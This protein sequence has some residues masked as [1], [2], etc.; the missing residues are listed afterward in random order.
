MVDRSVS[1]PRRVVDAD[2]LVVG[3]GAGAARTAVAAAEAGASTTVVLKKTLGRSGA[4]NYPRK[5]AYGS[6]WQAADGCS[7]RDD[8]PDLHYQDVMRAALGMADARMARTLAHESPER[9]LEIES[10]GFRLIPD[11]EG[12]RRH[13]AGYSCFATQPRAHGMVADESGGHTGNMIAVLAARFGQLGGQVDPDTTVVDLL[14]RDGACVGAL[15]IDPDGDLIAYRTGA[16]VLATGGASQMFPLS[17]TPGEITGDG[18]GMAFRAGGELVNLEFM[19]YMW[20][21][22]HGTPP[23]VGGPFWSLNPAVRGRDGADLLAAAL[24]PGVAAERVFHDRTLHYPFSSRDDGRWLDIAVQRAIRAGRGTARGGVTV[25]FSGV[26]LARARAPRPQHH[27]P[28]ATMG[29]GDPRIEVT[30]AAHA[31][32][33]GIRVS[34]WGE[35][36]VPGL[37]AVGET[38]GGPHGADRLGGGMLAACNVFGA[39]AGRRAAAYAAGAA[40]V[41]PTPALLERPLAR[42]AG[43][44]GGGAVTWGEIRRALKEL[45]AATLLVVRDGAG[46]TRMVDEARRLRHDVLPGASFGDA[47]S[48]AYLLETDNLLLTA[49]LMARAALAREES[50]GSHYREDFPE[51]DDGRWLVNLFWRQERDEPVARRARYRQDPDAPRQVEELASPAARP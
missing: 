13:Y 25:D 38:I 51:R 42:L 9:L 19:Q 10:W 43:F 36:T 35:S 44:R 22:I 4:T 14:V 46:L 11:P 49:E 1:S 41:A 31:I 6:A 34:E 28:R 37:Y 15:A 39:R 8:S 45:T 18:Y 29:P 3:G 16:V 5:G 2:V 33:G 40:R 48:L 27:P 20:R 7:G 17:T 47:R 21:P 26:D 50:R 23:D 12:R 24:P 30:H 32:N